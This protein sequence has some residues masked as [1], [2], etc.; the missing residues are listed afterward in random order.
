MNSGSTIKILLADDDKDDCI[1]FK[2]VL[3]EMDQTTSF[4]AVNDGEQLMYYLND[5]KNE[6]PSVLF[7]DIN[8]PRKNGAACLKEIKRNENL[9]QIPVI[10]F[11]TSYDE[12]IAG[13][14]Y[15]NGAHYYIRKPGEFSELKNI[16]GQALTLI[17][18]GDK[19]QPSREKFLLS[20]LK[21][22][23]Y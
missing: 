2:E 17:S 12:N 9:K 16:I 22:I 6:L 20:R 11:S 3:D 10:I 7:L 23:L 8:M 1:F 19:Q 13:V 14:L 15:K 21:P 18:K 5:E 4:K